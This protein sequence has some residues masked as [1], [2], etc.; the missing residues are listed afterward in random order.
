VTVQEVVQ[1]LPID[2][3]MT[4]KLSPRTMLV[5]AMLVV[6]LAAGIMLGRG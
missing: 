3:G 2:W 6:A 5:L 4:I 1:E